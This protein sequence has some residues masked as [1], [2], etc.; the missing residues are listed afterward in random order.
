[1][2]TFNKLFKVPTGSQ[3]FLKQLLIEISIMYLEEDNLMR[4]DYVPSHNEI[5]EQ[6]ESLSSNGGFEKVFFNDL[7]YIEC[8][9]N[10]EIKSEHVEIR[11][12]IPFLNLNQID[13]HLQNE[14]CYFVG[15][16]DVFKTGQIPLEYYFDK[17]L[18]LLFKSL[19]K[20]KPHLQQPS[21]F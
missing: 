13:Q 20:N 15:G 14:F 19:I 1:M 2:N 17:N 8:M 6:L 7:L 5:I 9:N 12:K 4:N 16:T 10:F 3:D 21:L 18:D 11:N